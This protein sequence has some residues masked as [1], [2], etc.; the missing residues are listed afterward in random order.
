MR[1]YTGNIQYFCPFISWRKHPIRYDCAA[2]I[3]GGHDPWIQGVWPSPYNA[4]DASW[5]TIPLILRC[6]LPPKRENNNHRNI[7]E[8]VKQTKNHWKSQSIQN[9]NMGAPSSPSNK[10]WWFIDQGCRAEICYVSGVDIENIYISYCLSKNTKHHDNQMM[11]MV[12]GSAQSKDHNLRPFYWTA[13]SQFTWCHLQWW[14]KYK[15]IFS[16][17]SW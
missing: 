2:F 4:G 16:R 9:L 5:L 14:Q 17:I 8:N 12:S 15:L 3:S 6:L 7:Q 13:G 1:S 11:I 10:I